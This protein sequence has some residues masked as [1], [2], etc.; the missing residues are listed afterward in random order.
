MSDDS[1]TALM[2]V[3]RFSDKHAKRR[4]VLRKLVKEGKATIV[5]NSSDGWLYRAPYHISTRK[6]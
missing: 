6:M 4:K 3:S 2:F 1:K 5:E